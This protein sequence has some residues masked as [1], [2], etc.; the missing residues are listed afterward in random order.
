M[1]NNTKVII[2]MIINNNI[3]NIIIIILLSYLLLL[4]LI[5]NIYHNI[6]VTYI[7]HLCYGIFF[8]GGAAARCALQDVKRERPKSRFAAVY[9]INPESP[10]PTPY[11]HGADPK[12]TAR[13]LLL[14]RQRLLERASC[15]R[16]KPLLSARG[17]LQDR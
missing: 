12:D 8:C 6:Q 14:A 11:R 17:T 16:E 2:I 15:S 10:T 1:I 13:R 4:I 7:Y 5:I 3:I 9:T